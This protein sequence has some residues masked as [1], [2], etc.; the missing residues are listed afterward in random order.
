MKILFFNIILLVSFFSTEVWGNGFLQ[1]KDTLTQVRKTK[2]EVYPKWQNCQ[3]SD[4]SREGFLVC[5]QIYLQENIQNPQNID[6]KVQG[7]VRISKQ[8]KAE[9]LDISASDSSLKDEYI[10]LISSMLEFVPAKSSGNAIDYDFLL[11]L[12]FRRKETNLKPKVFSNP[13]VYPKWD[14]QTSDKDSKTAFLEG[15]KKRL[16]E[17]VP[18]TDSLGNRRQVYMLVGVT[19]EGHLQVNEFYCPDEQVWAKIKRNILK[20]GRLIPA[21][22]K[23][24]NVY[25]ESLFSFSPSSVVF[26]RKVDRESVVHF[27]ILGGCD[28]IALSERT[29]IE[30]FQQCCNRNILENFIYPAE[31]VKNGIQGRVY[32]IFCITKEG[33]LEVKSLLGSDEILKIGALYVVQKIQ[34]LQSARVDGKPTDLF[35]T[36]PITFKIDK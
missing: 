18:S 3:E 10:R 21:Q 31:A 2:P 13:K 26:P 36:Y 19:D 23:K 32:V 8:G 11:P 29:T 34:V 7:K 17:G 14:S 6:G 22:E 4:G 25:F 30:A 33:K 5:M 35:F 27:P 15:L 16:F 12:T 1:V 9:V 28:D 24:E 20:A